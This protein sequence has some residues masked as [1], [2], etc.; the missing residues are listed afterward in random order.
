LKLRAGG[1]ASNIGCMLRLNFF[2]LD[3]GFDLMAI[4][5]VWQGFGGW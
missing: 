3:E 2:N 1:V 4:D 5:D